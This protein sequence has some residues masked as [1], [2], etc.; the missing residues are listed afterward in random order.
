MW[1]V[2]TLH[3]L[4]LLHRLLQHTDH[5]RLHILWPLLTNEA[6]NNFGATVFG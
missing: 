6:K 1:S 4:H 2:R 5:L 3:H